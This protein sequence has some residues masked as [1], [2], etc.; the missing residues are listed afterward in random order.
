MMCRDRV[1]AL[2]WL[3]VPPQT[4]GLSLCEGGIIVKKHNT[5]DFIHP[6]Y[7]GPSDYRI[8]RL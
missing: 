1:E 8:I 3:H 7:F 2:Q 6:R 4:R 5:Y